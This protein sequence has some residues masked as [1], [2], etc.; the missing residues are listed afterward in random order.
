MRLKN[1]KNAKNIIEEGKYYV[2][3]PCDYK[4]KWHELFQND[5]P[6]YLEIGMGKGK[7][8]LENALQNTDVNYIGIEKYDSVLVRAIQ[9]TNKFE[10]NNLKLIKIDAL[11]LSTIFDKEI[12]LI[13]QTISSHMGQWNT[14]NYSDINLPKPSNKYEFFVHMCDYL[15]SKKYWDVKFDENSNIIL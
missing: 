4:G 11:N 3:K 2:N 1:V 7:F 14:N 13:C 8:I 9:K 15:S 5:N 12:D 10:L 6:I